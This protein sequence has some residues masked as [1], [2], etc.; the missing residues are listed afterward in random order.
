MKNLMLVIDTGSSSM[1]GIL[2]DL[3]GRI[4]NQSKIFYRMDIEGDKATQKVTDF[5]N[6]LK[7]LTFQAV[8]Y[9]KK[10][11][12]EIVS[13][14]LTSQRSSLIVL[15]ENMSVVGPAIMWYDN[16]SR[17]VCDKVNRSKG[18]Y[19]KEISG[20]LSDTKLLAPKISY[21]QETDEMAIKAAHYMCIQ[22]YLIWVITGNL[23]TDPTL[24]CRTNLMDIRK[25]DWSEELLDIYHVDRE[26]LCKII[27]CGSKAGSVKETYFRETGLK[28][29]TPVFTAGGD[30]QCA[31]LGQMFSWENNISITLGTGGYV[32][33]VIDEIMCV[34][35]EPV[36]IVSSVWP[37]KFNL[38][39]G[40]G[41]VGSLFAWCIDQF[42]ESQGEPEKFLK[43]ASQGEIKEGMAEKIN[44][45]ILENCMIC[46]KD[47][48]FGE[49]RSD[50]EESRADIALKTLVCILKKV[51]DS[52]KCVR[53][54]AKGATTVQIAGGMAK[55]DLVCRLLQRM[56]GT[57]LEKSVE[58]ET[59]AL[60]AWL[61]SMVALNYAPDLK[62]AI[63]MY[64][65]EKSC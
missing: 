45:E 32:S 7:K 3:K 4:V 13:I 42:E 56:L 9:A 14:A 30:Q 54:Y 46:H 22:D 36:Q 52:Y 51:C 23:V 40:I 47:F 19:I 41:K 65:A 34:P 15:D 2:F 1:R 24:A 5:A 10:N 61:Q 44:Y 59:T 28:Q 27:P 55:S 39:M 18:E 20:S 31:L 57:K 17:Y 35:D 50:S 58:T 26:K 62:A 21:F 64:R 38:E 8:C 25:Q 49:F 37:K 60:G 63:Q 29:G 43:L 11:D 48:P 16:R 6:A 12:F 33:M 53:E